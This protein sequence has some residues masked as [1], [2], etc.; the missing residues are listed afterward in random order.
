MC[1]RYGLFADL[2]DLGTQLEFDPT[3][4]RDAYL[5]R[6]NIA[7]TAPALVIES[8]EGVGRIGRIL[9]WGGQAPGSRPRYNIRAETIAGW[10]GWHS[11]WTYRRC[12]VRANGFYE[13]QTGPD[14]RRMPWW[15][16]PADDGLM[17]MAGIRFGN[18]ASSDA[19]CTVITC[20]AN[21]LVKPVHHRMPAVLEPAQ[22]GE[23]LD[24]AG[25]TARLLERREWPEIAARAV[26]PA[27]NRAVNDG[28]NLIAALSGDAAVSPR[29]LF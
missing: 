16:Q 24:G 15:F 7:P 3:A 20:P 19:Y 22:F 21:N 2:D 14:R 11:G 10:S 29:L 6:W 25:P 28:P 26:S 4:V 13:W 27:V 8:A 18:A 17:V 23:W 12:L 5:P 1:G 9:P